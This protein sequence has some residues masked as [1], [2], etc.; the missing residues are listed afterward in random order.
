[1]SETQV[2]VIMVS[3]DLWDMTRKALETLIFTMS[4]PWELI[5]INNGSKDETRKA[6]EAIAPTWK[7]QYFNGYQVHHYARPVSLASAWNRAWGMR[8]PSVRYAL[9]ANN[10]IVFHKFGW[11]DRMREALDPSAGSG[12]GLALTGIQE[13]S[14]YRFRFVE[15]SLLAARTE[16][17]AG[18]EEDGRLFD[19][20]FKLSCEDVDLSE[21]F[22]RAGLEIGQTHGLQPEWLVHI[23]HQTLQKFGPTEDLVGKMH[24]ARRALCKK[25]GYPEQ[26]GD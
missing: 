7:W 1:M 14:W 25:W 19:P 10:D 9:F 5:F 6:F 16:T 22:L 15:G 24:D 26:V 12:Q 23:G 20:R 13:M 3:R 11:W 8:S 4:A 17:L 2:S 18:M 21:R